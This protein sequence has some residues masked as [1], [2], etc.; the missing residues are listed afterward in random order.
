MSEERTEKFAENMEVRCDVC[1]KIFP[2]SEEGKRCP[3]CGIG[4]I[5]LMEKAA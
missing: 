1:R 3:E 2:A 4:R 5:W